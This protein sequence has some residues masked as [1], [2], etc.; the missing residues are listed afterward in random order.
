M[1]DLQIKICRKKHK[2]RKRVSILEVGLKEQWILH[3]RGEFMLRKYKKIICATVIII[4][5]FALYTVNKI[6]F[7]HDPEFERAVRNTTI[8]NAVSGALQKEYPMLQGESPIKGIIWKKDLENIN[9]V[10]IDFREYR[11]KDIS[12][13]KYFKN[14]EIVVLGYSSAYTGDKSIYEEEHVLDN[15]YK[16]KNLKYLDKLQLY[17]LKLDDKDIENIKEMFPNVRVVIE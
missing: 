8:D 4:I 6:A 14:A 9:L 3:R 17:N 16:A 12:D 13:I 7:F 10:S 1:T 5:V 11:V 2:C 15:L